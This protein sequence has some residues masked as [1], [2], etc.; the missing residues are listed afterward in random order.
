MNID[1]LEIVELE[2]K[3]CERC[4]TLWLRPCRNEQVYCSPCTMK[5]LSLPIIRK[6]RVKSQ[7][8]APDDLCHMDMDGQA[9]PVGEGGHA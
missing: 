4:G 3:Y 6:P 5:M 7:S 1:E 8:A 2:L 9:L